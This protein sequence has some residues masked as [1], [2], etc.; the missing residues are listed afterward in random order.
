HREPRAIAVLRRCRNVIRIAA[1]AEADELTI[2]TRAAA[3]RVLELLEN[4]RAAA[5][6]EHEPIAV[7]VPRAA[8]LLRRVVAGRQGL[9]LAES[10][11]PA[12]GRRHLP[13]AGQHP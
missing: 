4:D 2:D 10:A 7:E 13:A 12:G 1:H 11:E 3:L 9:R 6:G 8:R 5:V